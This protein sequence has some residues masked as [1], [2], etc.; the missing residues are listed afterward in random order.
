MKVL[1]FKSFEEN[2]IN[3]IDDKSNYLQNYLSK[4]IKR[5]VKVDFLVG[6]NTLVSKEGILKETG[7]DYIVLEMVQSNDLLVCDIYSIK[8]VQ[9]I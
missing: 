4:S 8:F 2:E 3:E 6:D 5:F 9:I 1:K 7:N